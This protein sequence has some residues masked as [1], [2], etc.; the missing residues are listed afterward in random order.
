MVFNLHFGVAQWEL[1]SNEGCSVILTPE[2][3][4]RVPQDDVDF[5]VEG[6]DLRPAPQVLRDSSVPGSRVRSKGV[7]P[8]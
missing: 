7:R 6:E 4:L 8:S 2:G 5:V 3:R 1:S